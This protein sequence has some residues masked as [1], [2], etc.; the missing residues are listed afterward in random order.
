[1]PGVREAAAR[2]DWAAAN[3]QLRQVQ[4]VIDRGTATLKRA[5]KD[6]EEISTVGG[7]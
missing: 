6:L 3:Q 7:R 5:V 2:K 4:V 1:L